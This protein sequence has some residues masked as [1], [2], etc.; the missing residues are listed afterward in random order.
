MKKTSYFCSNQQSRFIPYSLALF[1][2]FIVVSVNACSQ[3]NP[4]TESETRTK[5]NE[6]KTS[7]QRYFSNNW[8][9]IA[10]L[11]L[12]QSEEQNLDIRAQFGGGVTK[13]LLQTNNSIL[14]VLGGAGVNR[15]K[16]SEESFQTSIEGLSGIGFQTFKF[17]KPELDISTNLYAFPNFNR[18]TT[19]RW[20][21]FRGKNYSKSLHSW[22]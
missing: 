19:T 3:K 5:R 11:N 20:I 10:I 14:T 6:L 7:F 8:S 4:D 18:G 12:L 13:E 9:A 15:E 17:D 16:Y 2:V 22:N 21:R 1:L